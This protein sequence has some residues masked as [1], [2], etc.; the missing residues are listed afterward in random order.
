MDLYGYASEESNRRYNEF[1]G[2]YDLFGNTPKYDRIMLDKGYDPDAMRLVLDVTTSEKNMPEAKEHSLRA[3][4]ANSL[5]RFNAISNSLTQQAISLVDESGD[6]ETRQDAFEQLSGR[7]KSLNV[8]LDK[9]SR[10]SM[11]MLAIGVRPGGGRP[12]PSDG[13]K[14]FLSRLK[15]RIFKT[16][17][18]LTGEP[19]SSN[20]TVMSAEE[21]ALASEGAIE[22]ASTADGAFAVS[23]PKLISAPKNPTAYVDQYGVTSFNKGC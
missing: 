1:R 10:I 5:A 13:K 22:M 12:Q 4:S 20:L 21:T 6:L 9:T 17:S 15:E 3:R 8:V 18:K 7:A 23:T 2:L 19:Q 16:K 11:S 14:N